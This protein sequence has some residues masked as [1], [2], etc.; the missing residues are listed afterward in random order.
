MTKKN[1]AVDKI[2]LLY[3]RVNKHSLAKLCSAQLF[4]NQTGANLPPGCLFSPPPKPGGGIAYHYRL[5]SI[6]FLSAFSSA[7]SMVS[8]EPK[9]TFG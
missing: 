7:F 3:T 6:A 1:V 4:T 9:D 2:S 5:E 8:P